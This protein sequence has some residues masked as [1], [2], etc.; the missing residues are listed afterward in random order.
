M[1]E[2][3]RTEVPSVP[4]E[5]CDTNVVVYAFDRTAGEKRPQA[6]AL[7]DRLWAS[8]SG[9]ISV[10][11]LQEAYVVFTRRL[12]QSLTVEDA[13]AIVEDLSSWRVAVPSAL[14]VLAAIDIAQRWKVSFWDAMILQAA[15]LAGARIVWSEDLSDGQMIAG[16]TIRNP[17]AAA[18]R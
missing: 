13:R 17:F 5:F 18:P 1:T 11:V 9:A 4:L 6:R 10:Q 15:L 12:R 8:G 14:D 16:V 7:L 2:V 3:P